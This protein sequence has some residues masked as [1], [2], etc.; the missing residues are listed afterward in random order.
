M[1]K[2]IKRHLVIFSVISIVFIALLILL[3]YNI[4]SLKQSFKLIKSTVETQEKVISKYEKRSISNNSEKDAILI[5]HMET[6]IR[7]RYTKTPKVI[8]KEIPITIIRYSKQYD[9][10]P[11]LLLGIIEVESMFNPLTESSKGAKGLMQVMPEW[12][13]KLG[14]ES[15]N[16]LHDIDTGIESGIKVFLI[17]LEEAKGN[18]S[19][20][21]YRYVNKDHSYVDRVYSS[22]GRFIAYSSTLEEPEK[23]VKKEKDSDN[24][25]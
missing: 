19:G 12:A 25:N 24:T 20:G 4:K 5:R 1:E 14:L 18:I 15:A 13:P 21:L 2:N 9:V 16:D 7:N 10:S 17:H 3:N 6:Y 23:I 8:A 22:I 11:E